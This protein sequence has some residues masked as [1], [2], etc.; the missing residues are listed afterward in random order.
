MRPNNRGG[1]YRMG[2]DSVD[3]ALAD[4]AHMGATPDGRRR[5][6]PISKNLCASSGMQKRGILAFMQSLL[7]LDQAD[8]MGSAPL[9]FMVHPSAV[10]GDAGL[11]AM[12]DL[13]RTYFDRGGMT[14]HGNIVKAEDLKAAKAAPEKYRDLQVRVCGWN[15]Y[16]VNLSSDQ[17]DEFIAQAE[18]L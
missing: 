13:L 16:F 15:D 1:V 3:F 5:G 14:I 4:G 18:V 2:S 11:E 6:K 8:I 7:K 17:Q 12:A 10:R 9:D